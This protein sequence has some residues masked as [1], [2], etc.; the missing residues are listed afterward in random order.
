MT[1]GEEVTR[2]SIVGT[3]RLFGIRAKP[4]PRR[5]PECWTQDVRSLSRRESAGDTQYLRG[6]E[7]RNLRFSR[8][9]NGMIFRVWYHPV[10]HGSKSQ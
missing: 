10:I 4:S 2:R 8:R 5:K 3:L 7:R 9:L 1:F 6:F